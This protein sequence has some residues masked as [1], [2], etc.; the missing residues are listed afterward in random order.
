MQNP[1]LFCQIIAWDYSQKH[2]ETIRNLFNHRYGILDREVQPVW[3]APTLKTNSR[4]W[5]P[6]ELHVHSDINIEPM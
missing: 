4:L 6:K 5:L 1:A 2:Q 3:A